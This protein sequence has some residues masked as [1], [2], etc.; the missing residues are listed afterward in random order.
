MDIDTN[1]NIIIAGNT[2]S[3][4]GLATSGTQQQF[5]ASFDDAFIAKFSSSGQL[6]WSTYFGGN[7][8]ELIT[9][10]KVDNQNKI[11]VTGHTNSSDLPC[12]ANAERN[13]LND[14][15]NAFLGVYNQTG[16]LYYIILIIYLDL[17][18][19]EESIAI[20]ENGTIYFSGKSS[21]TT[22]YN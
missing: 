4:S 17:V 9:S 10:V 5:I 22:S 15:E 18:M 11:Y 14:Y 20:A 1:E 3:T 21:D 8:H 16:L 2:T 12:T 13:T 6:M 7:N 19:L